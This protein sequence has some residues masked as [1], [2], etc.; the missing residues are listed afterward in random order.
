MPKLDE[1]ELP[2]GIIEP[3][4]DQT[5]WRYINFYQFVSLLLRGKLY[6]NRADQFSD[7]FEGSL[8]LPN[9]EERQEVI[10]EFEAVD[11]AEDVD[12]IASYAYQSYKKFTFLNCWHVRNR[13][14]AAM[15]ELY[16]GQ[17]IAI[18]STASDLRAA[19]EN[20]EKTFRLV[21]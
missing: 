2:E 13:E 1:G 7:P 15:W 18:R 14:S 12:E 4:W 10:E 6:F 9:V 19:L 20:L 17:G 11:T 3:E 5:I 8:P 21:W 16:S